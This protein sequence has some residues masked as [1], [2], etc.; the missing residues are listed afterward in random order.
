MAGDDTSSGEHAFRFIAPM[1]G[2]YRLTTDRWVEDPP[3]LADTWL[4]VLLAGC[5][6]TY[7]DIDHTDVC[8]DDA[9][10][11]T[12][13]SSTE[14]DLDRGD[15]IFIVVDGATADDAGRNYG[16]WVESMP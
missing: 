12:S 7:D 3:D 8:N 10:P 15:V 2:R 16:V 14:I 4:Y 9:G 11:G 1:T 13:L 5:R 6:A